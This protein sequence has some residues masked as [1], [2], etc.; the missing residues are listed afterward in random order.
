MYYKQYTNNTYRYILMSMTRIRYANLT[1]WPIPNSMDW[2]TI[3]SDTRF[4][5]DMPLSKPMPRY[6][7]L[8]PLEQTSTNDEHFCQVSVWR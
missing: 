8:D 3:G 1:W 2:V 4:S 7:Y 5:G 6:Y